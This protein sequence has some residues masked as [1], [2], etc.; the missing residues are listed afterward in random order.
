M[1]AAVYD[2]GESARAQVV[3]DSSQRR[4][5]G[6]SEGREI[7]CRLRRERSEAFER[8]RSRPPGLGG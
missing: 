8:P 1:L 3:V 2:R 4:Y 5:W 6:A 7:A